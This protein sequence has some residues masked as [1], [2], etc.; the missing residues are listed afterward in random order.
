MK[1]NYPCFPKG[2]YEKICALN[3]N[4]IEKTMRKRF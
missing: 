1:S 4:V 2:I 3:A